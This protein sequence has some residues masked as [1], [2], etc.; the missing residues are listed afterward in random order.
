[1]SINSRSSKQN[2][3]AP[4]RDSNKYIFKLWH[5][6]KVD[7]KAEHNMIEHDGKTWYWCNNHHYNNK[8]VMTNG[9][10]VTHKPQDHKQW[11]LNKEKRKKRKSSSADSDSTTS[12]KSKSV[13]VLN[14]SAASKLSLSKSLQAALVTTAG[15]T[16]SQ[17][18]KIWKDACSALGN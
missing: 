4:A 18:K 13:C 7:N 6:N 10:Y 9:M 15:I 2:E 5:L 14:D 12:K 16:E 17:F 8:G 1:M 11:R 3:E